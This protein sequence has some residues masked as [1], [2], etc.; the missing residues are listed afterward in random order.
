MNDAP[1]EQRRDKLQ[2]PLWIVSDPARPA[3]SAASE[4][5]TWTLT[6][7]VPASDER[8]S[9]APIQGLR[10][11]VAKASASSASRL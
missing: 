1:W 11:L 9:S 10:L 8:Q 4:S 6:V 5:S 2:R 3:L 7:E